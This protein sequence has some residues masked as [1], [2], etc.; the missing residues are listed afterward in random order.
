MVFIIGPHPKCVRHRAQDEAVAR[1]RKQR[2]A[3]ALER[4][5]EK[6]PQAVWERGGGRTRLRGKGR[7][8]KERLDERTAKKGR[9][10]GKLK[11]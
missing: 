5:A 3:A 8:W 1:R 10:T 11:E 6:E 7:D 9:K 2:R 4:T